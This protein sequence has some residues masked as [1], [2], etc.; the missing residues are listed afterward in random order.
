MFGDK[1]MK[2]NLVD[3]A[4]GAISTIAQ[5]EYDDGWERWGIQDYVWSPDSRWI[6]YTQLREN[7]NECVYLYNLEKK[8]THPV[9]DDM[10]TSWSPSFDPGGKY[11]Y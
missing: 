4:G 6:A 3:A 7:M 10:T 1:Y 5:G 8:K 2:L 11:L 9:T